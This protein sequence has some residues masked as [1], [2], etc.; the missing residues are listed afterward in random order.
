[1]AFDFGTFVNSM[2]SIGIFQYLFPFL[3]ALAIIYGALMYALGDKLKK[4]PVG[5]ISIVLSFFVMLYASSEPMI[6]GFFAT[7]G[8]TTLIVASGILV[9]VVLLGL[10][11]FKLHE[12]FEGKYMKW[13]LVFAIILIGLIVFFG[14]SGGNFINVPG[15]IIN[16]DFTVFIIV[17][18]IIAL[19]MWFMTQEG[20]GEKPK[21]EAPKK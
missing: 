16:S 15:F 7:L 5:L 4:G 14:A 20:G 1:M 9:I 3:L 11:G 21:E 19:A 17:I 18:V 10:A 12:V 6:V 2:Q 13:F 8:G